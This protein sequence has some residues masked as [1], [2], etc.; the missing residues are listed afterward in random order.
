M[1][2]IYFKNHEICSER[3]TFINFSFYGNKAISRGTW[4]RTPRCERD[5]IK[6][7]NKTDWYLTLP[8][9]ALGI[10]RRDKVVVVNEDDQLSAIENE[11]L[12]SKTR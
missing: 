11:E 10:T 2:I 7:M 1:C 8:G 6:S 3:I 9:L 12:Y 4:T 5:G